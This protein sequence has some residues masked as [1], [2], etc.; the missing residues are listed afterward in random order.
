M[1]AIEPVLH[2]RVDDRGV[3]W[4]DESNVKVVEVI[5]DHVAYGYSPEEI[6]LQH[7]HLSLAQIYAAFAYY[8][9][10]AEALDGEIDR[11]YREVEAL[12]TKAPGNP[13]RA[14]LQARLRR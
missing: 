13:S 11:R 6:R 12:R 2:V 1:P 9:D 3:A 4:I 14:D 5:T 7:P 10:H 8:H